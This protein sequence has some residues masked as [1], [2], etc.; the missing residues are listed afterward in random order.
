MVFW[1]G[2]NAASLCRERRASTRLP[3]CG[4]LMVWSTLAPGDTACVLRLADLPSSLAPMMNTAL[5]FGLNLAGHDGY[6]T[7]ASSHCGLSLSSSA[8][9]AVAEWSPVATVRA[10]AL[11]LDVDP[12]SPTRDNTAT[13]VSVAITA[14]AMT[15][16]SSLGGVCILRIMHRSVPERMRPRAPRIGC[17]VRSRE[18]CHSL[19]RW[20]SRKRAAARR[21]KN[22]MLRT[23]PGYTMR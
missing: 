23:K 3:N 22:V 12:K 13:V 18:F 2:S 14:Q 10:G 17:R 8:R 4:I 20:T 15:H 11:R 7:S 5:T 6:T 1:C 21:S 19:Y 9:R 16:S